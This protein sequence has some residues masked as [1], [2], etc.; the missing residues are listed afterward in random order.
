MSGINNYYKAN[1]GYNSSADSMDNYINNYLQEPITS[2]NNKLD[3]LRAQGSSLVEAGGAIEGLYAGA[4]GLQGA[5]GTL[6]SKIAG[7]SDSA[8]DGAVGA[9]AGAEGGAEG[10][11]ETGIELGT[12]AGQ[13][14]ATGA[15]VAGE[16]GASDIVGA[17]TG[18]GI[19]EGVGEG[20]G[21]GIGLAVG[22]TV[23]EA[24][25]VIGGLAAIGI[26][27]YE[28]FHKKKPPPPNVLKTN[29]VNNNN[30]ITVPSYDSVVDQPASSSVF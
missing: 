12:V 16:S 21:E 22:A 1:N 23:A 20:I 10:V 14:G 30:E 9:D 5:I 27:L 8:T 28:L 24:V 19:G 26:G 4:K 29:Q 17:G 7:Q 18:I 15:E 13:A 3:S 25:P 11:G 2:F 6:K